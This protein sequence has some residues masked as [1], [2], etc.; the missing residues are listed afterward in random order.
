M[1]EQ[2]S[3]GRATLKALVVAISATLAVWW[4]AVTALAI[5]AEFPPLAGPAPTIFFT[6]IGTLGAAGVLGIVRRRA[7]HPAATFRRIA[8]MALVL[9]F[10]P[11]LWLLSGSSSFPG[12][13]S[14]GVGVLMV[15]HIV[16]ALTIVWG[17]I[18]LRSSSGP[19]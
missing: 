4:L 3:L 14:T 17:L 9:S 13:T 19:S 16:A 12:A 7:T 8:L 15:L 2:S 5:P 11:D 10:L 18:G 1:T 6:V